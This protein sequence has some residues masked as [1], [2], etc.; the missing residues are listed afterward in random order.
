MDR[1]NARGFSRSC[2]LRLAVVVVRLGTAIASFEWELM[3]DLFI[4][5]VGSPLADWVPGPRRAD[6]VPS[7]D[8]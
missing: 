6:G 3:R 1:F 2:W 8:S 4:G 5:V 7:D